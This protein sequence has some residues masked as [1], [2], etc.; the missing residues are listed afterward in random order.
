[1]NQHVQRVL[2]SVDHLSLRERLFLF[3]AVL[4]VLG[5][6]WEAL[7]AA[8]LD[9]RERLAA[10]QI[11]S[12]QERLN[13]VNESV[14]VAAEGMSDGVPGQ[15]DRLRVLRDR[16]KHGDQAVLLATSDLIDPAQMRAVLE[17]LIRSQ[18]G[19]ELLSATNLEVRPLFDDAASE[20]EAGT[21]DPIVPP[22]GP[23]LYQ[24]TLVLTLRG[25][26]LD[27]LRYLE[28]AERLPWHLYW[29]RLELKADSYPLNTIVIELRTLSLEEGWIGV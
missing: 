14:V 12:L 23:K 27:C 10:E 7:L 6:L 20:D 1:M 21:T 5:G 25:S 15:L 19:L 2:Q 17:E 22:E 26:Y 29:A 13:Q 4:V 16:V 11:A 24:H 8:P 3:G 28:A 18:T 9:A